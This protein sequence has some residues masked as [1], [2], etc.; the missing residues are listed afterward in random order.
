MRGA[1]ITTFHRAHY[2]LTV[3]SYAECNGRRTKKINGENLCFIF[4]RALNMRLIKQKCLIRR[5]VI[6]PSL[7]GASSSR[8]FIKNE[9]RINKFSFNIQILL[10]RKNHPCAHGTWNHLKYVDVI[11]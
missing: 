9:S 2:V 4:I 3:A 1:H 7:L 10:S 5:R 8:A 11:I 6:R